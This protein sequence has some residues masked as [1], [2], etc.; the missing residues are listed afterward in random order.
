MSVRETVQRWIDAP[1]TIQRYTNPDDISS[2][3]SLSPQEVLGQVDPLIEIMPY[4][5]NP[6]MT[7]MSMQVKLQQIR[8]VPSA[9][10]VG[11]LATFSKWLGREYRLPTEAEWE[12]A[13]RAGTTTRYAVGDSLSQENANFGMHV[14]RTTEVRTYLPNRW[15]LFDMHGNV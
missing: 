2:G 6:H 9:L 14:D 7:Y 10:I 15:G 5:Q 1:I 3:T 4:P 8:M 12:Y 13:C 11:N